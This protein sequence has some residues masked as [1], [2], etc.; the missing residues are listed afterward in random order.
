[1]GSPLKR[2][3]SLI[4]KGNRR[5]MALLQKTLI[6]TFL[7]IAVSCFACILYLDN[8][9]GVNGATK[10]EPNEGRIYP[11]TLHHGVHVFMTKGEKFRF[12]VVLPSVSI[13]SFLIAALLNMRWKRFRGSGQDK[14][15]I[16]DEDVPRLEK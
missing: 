3:A 5:F 6:V 16:I 4:M 12:D 13:G 15:Q 1:V 14:T 7:A 2:Y 9:Y 8:Y 10:P 11:K